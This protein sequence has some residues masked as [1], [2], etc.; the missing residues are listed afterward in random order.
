MFGGEV[1][2]HFILCVSTRSWYKRDA[3]FRSDD[4]QGWSAASIVSFVLSWKHAESPFFL[5][6]FYTLPF[7]GCNVPQFYTS[8]SGY[9]VL[10]HFPLLYCFFYF[11]QMCCCVHG[12]VFIIF[13]FSFFRILGSFFS[14]FSFWHWKEK[15]IS[16][17]H[18]VHPNNSSLTV[19]LQRFPSLSSTFLAS[20]SLR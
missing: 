8:S 9:P 3:L 17:F 4:A 10:L 14:S 5:F 20:V 18:S 11:L 15:K 7:K 6:C 19:S 13:L 16:L 2:P 1:R 12:S